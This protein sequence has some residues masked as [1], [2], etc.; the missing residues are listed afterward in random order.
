M[1][2]ATFHFHGDF[3]ELLTAPHKN[4]T[5][6]YGLLRRAS[7]KDI[8]EALG[9]PHTEVAGLAAGD[10]DI[11]FSFLVQDQ[12]LIR[13]LAPSPPVDVLTPTLLRPQPL[14][15]IRFLAD[16]NVAKLGRLLRMA[17]FDVLDGK[18]RNDAGLAE[19][20]ATEGRIML[21]RD[22][23]LLRR[24]MVIFG[25]LVRAEDP[26]AQLREVVE[27][28]GLASRLAP[29]SRCMVCNGLLEPVAREQVLH[30]LEPLT[31]KYYQVFRRCR[32]CDRLYWAGSHRQGM[33]RVLQGL[34]TATRG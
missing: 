10:K 11:D 31:R 14:P 23:L 16:A 34:T 29:F 8:I 21:T 28:Y 4:G 18:D 3:F 20:A 17:G 13:V 6:E 33:E 27:F 22:R 19:L 24:K 26:H 12:N 7:V 9:V 30:R 32:E 5:V 2:T 25:R 1:N 15:A